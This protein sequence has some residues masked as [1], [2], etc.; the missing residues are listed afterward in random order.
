VRLPSF[1]EA[2]LFV[3]V[4][5]TCVCKDEDDLGLLSQRLSRLSNGLIV[6]LVSV[7]ANVEKRREER[8]ESLALILTPSW[9]RKHKHV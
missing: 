2:L 8:E 3:V 9:A 6:K 4:A 5:I 7:F 1:K